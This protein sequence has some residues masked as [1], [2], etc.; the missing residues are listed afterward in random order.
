MNTAK[1]IGTV[2]DVCLFKDEDGDV[3][4]DVSEL[5]KVWLSN[6]DVPEYTVE[7]FVAQVRAACA[8][9]REHVIAAARAFIAA[10]GAD[11]DTFE[12]LV[13]AV[14]RLEETECDD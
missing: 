4:L 12:A 11:D 5:D 7:N 14:Q 6:I 3:Y 8:D 10:E 9:P 2:L 1:R 13:S